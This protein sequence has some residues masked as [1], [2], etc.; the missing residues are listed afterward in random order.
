MAQGKEII[1]KHAMRAVG[2]EK[3]EDSRYNTVMEHV[4]DYIQ[5]EYHKVFALR[6]WVHVTNNIE[7]L[8]FEDLIFYAC[9]FWVIRTKW[10]E[11]VIHDILNYLGILISLRDQFVLAIWGNFPSYDPA[12]EE[13]AVF[14]EQIALYRIPEFEDDQ[15]VFRCLDWNCRSELRVRPV[16]GGK[17]FDYFMKGKPHICYYP[18]DIKYLQLS[19]DVLWGKP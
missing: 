7:I 5:Y 14:L 11:N 10:T 9:T 17:G 18:Y 19:G 12:R 8:S 2:F 4:A 3:I 13:K 6:K 16:S 15:L 1:R